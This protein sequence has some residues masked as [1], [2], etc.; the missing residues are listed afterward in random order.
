MHVITRRRIMKKYI[1]G[2]LL[3]GVLLFALCGCGGTPLAKAYDSLSALAEEG[4]TGEEGTDDVERSNLGDLWNVQFDEE[5][6]ALY[7][8]IDQGA[9]LDPIFEALNKAVDGQDIGTLMFYLDG[10][11]GDDYEKDLVKKIGDLPCNSLA[12]LGLNFSI[13]DYED[14]SWVALA[15]KTEKLYLETNCSVFWDY[16]D[17]ELKTLSNIKDVELAQESYVRLSGISKLSGME[18][19]SF[20]PAYTFQ[21]ADAD[22]SAEEEDPLAAVTEDNPY[23]NG[24]SADDENAAV[25]EIEADSTEASTDESGEEAPALRTFDYYAST[26][27]GVTDLANTESLKT[28]LIYPDTGYELT[29]GGQMFIKKVQYLKPAI[30]INAPG[31]AGTDD[32]VAITDVETPDVTDDQAADILASILEKDVDGVYEECN[33]YGKADGDA[34]LNGKVLVYVA[35]PDMDDWSDKKVYSSIGDVEILGPQKAGIKVPESVGDY[36][37]FVYIY[38]TYKRAGVYTSGTKAYAQTLNVQVFDMVDKVAYN[39][40]A[41]GTEQPP[42]SFSYFAD[43]VPDKHSGEVSIDKAYDYLAGLKTK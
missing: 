3:M 26:D 37:T 14:H 23:L 32:L 36:Q 35:D 8:Y 19:L 20:V 40:K 24:G 17:K 12:K 6:D 31:K 43:S 7:I 28:L 21:N 25:A 15:E 42:Q 10:T 11:R 41:V 38:P 22:A 1:I 34:V 27:D 4:Q 9:E 30:Q 13:L 18:T 33:K 29:A 2:I 39:A 5:N 16:S